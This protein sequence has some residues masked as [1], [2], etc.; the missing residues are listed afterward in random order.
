MDSFKPNSSSHNGVAIFTTK[1]NKPP[2][3]YLF[4][5]DSY[6]S[7]KNKPYESNVFEAAGNKWELVLFPGD[8]SKRNDKNHVALYLRLTDTKKF[9]AGWTLDV[10]LKMFIVDQKREQYLTVQLQVMYRPQIHLV[11]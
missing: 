9:S 5:I 10:Y 11:R 2:A 6:S 7:L 1:R 3:D 4:K 8:N